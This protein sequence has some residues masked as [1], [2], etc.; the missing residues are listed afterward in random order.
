MKTQ[1]RNI[2]PWMAALVC[3]TLAQGT[4]AG[5][6][7]DAPKASTSPE[8]S[9][10]TKTSEGA[11][12]KFNKA[13]G[14]VGMDVR[15]QKDERL[16]HIKDLVIDWKTEQVSYAVIS[17]GSKVLLDINEKLLAV[18]LTALTVSSDQKHLILNADK[19][20][21]AAAMGFDS[22]NWPSVSN[23]SWGAEP[24][25]QKETTTP[26]MSDQPAKESGAK[27]SSDMTPGADTA[28]DPNS[29]LG[30][31]EP[32][33]APDRDSPAKSDTAPESKSSDDSKSDSTTKDNAKPD[34]DP[35]ST[36]K[37][38]PEGK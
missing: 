27:A 10:E 12:A 36:P 28:T 11:P 25:W 37:Q 5:D 3:L 31:E 32:S 20:K 22:A 29:S 14:I 1:S 2:A 17:T 9:S 4:K 26:P 16:G 23:P 24:F 6:D 18:P 8:M 38:D 19:S 35:E 15:N 30:G 33:V 7:A 34:Q 21:V 13:S